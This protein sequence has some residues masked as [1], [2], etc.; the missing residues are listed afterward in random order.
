MVVAVH[1]EKLARIALLVIVD[2]EDAHFMNVCNHIGEVDARD[3][4]AN[5]ALEVADIE[6]PHEFSPSRG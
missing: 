6:Y 3:G 4:L 2:D 1:A 5:A